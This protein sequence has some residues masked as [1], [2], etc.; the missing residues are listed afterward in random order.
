MHILLI[1]S[2]VLLN[3]S[4]QFLIKKGMIAIGEINIIGIIQNIRLL[5][6]NIW[7]WIALV[8]YMLSFFLW[9]NVLS[10][11]EVSFAYPFLSIGYVISLIIGHFLFGENISTIRIIGIII[12]CIGV[13]IISKS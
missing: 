2:S 1:L 3:C 4:A 8:C 5:I 6:L 12:I 13:F 9:L 11:L 10:K 7:L